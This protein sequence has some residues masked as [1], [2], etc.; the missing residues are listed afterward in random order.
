VSA[1]ATA[2]RVQDVV[3]SL[4][5]AGLSQRA[6]ATAVGVGQATVSRDLGDPNGSGD[7]VIADQASTIG[8]DGK[9]YTPPKPPEPPPDAVAGCAAPLQRDGRLEA[10]L[11]HPGGPNRILLRRRANRVQSGDSGRK[12]RVLRSPHYQP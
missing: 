5:Q 8:L 12:A 9:T 3:L 10:A 4:K 7:A 11:A 2:G 1:E 6:I